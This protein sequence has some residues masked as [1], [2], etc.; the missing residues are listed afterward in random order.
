MT[1]GRPLIVYVPAGILPEMVDAPE[2]SPVTDNQVI[3][4]EFN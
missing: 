4:C 1:L 3:P 2:K